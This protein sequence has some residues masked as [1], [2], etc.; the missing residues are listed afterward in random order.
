MWRERHTYYLCEG[1]PIT[2]SLSYCP[3]LFVP[4][5]DLSPGSALVVHVD[6]GNEYGT[7][8]NILATIAGDEDLGDGAGPTEAP[9]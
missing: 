7:L 4:P 6:L 8:T 5:T 9:E 1:S 3:L 2:A